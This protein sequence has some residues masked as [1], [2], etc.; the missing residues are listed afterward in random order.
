[1]GV[2]ILVAKMHEKRHL[3]RVT[4][5]WTMTQ[6]SAMKSLLLL[7]LGFTPSACQTAWVFF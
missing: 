6:G 2:V 7:D 3:V 5:L 1:M 4:V